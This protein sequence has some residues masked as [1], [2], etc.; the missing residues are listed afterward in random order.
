MS[1]FERTKHCT[2]KVPCRLK[3]SLIIFTLAILV[4]IITVPIITAN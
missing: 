1:V 3:L 2:H 4:S